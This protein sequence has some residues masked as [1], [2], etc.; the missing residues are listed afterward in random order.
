[1]Q[2]EKEASG[3]GYLFGWIALLALTAVSF[4][5]SRLQLG[6]AATPVALGIAGVKVAVVGLVF[7]HLA[8]ARP[9]LQ[10]VALT[11]VVFIAL[12]VLGVAGDVSFR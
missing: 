5:L 11:S 2:H 9:A 10:L 6:R 12:L 7:M 3:R 4:G 1:M 8:R